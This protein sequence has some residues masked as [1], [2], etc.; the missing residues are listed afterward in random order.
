MG[1]ING[2]VRAIQA[3]GRIY[4]GNMTLDG[5]KNGFGV[6]IHSNGY[7]YACW[8]RDN[9]FHGNF[10]GIMLEDMSIDC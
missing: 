2:I 3:D 10:I 4:E 1:K 8:W 6:L 5:N 7:A 9:V